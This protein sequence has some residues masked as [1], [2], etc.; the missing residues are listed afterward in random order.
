MYKFLCGH[1]FL[2]LW[3]VYLGVGF[4]GHMVNLYLTF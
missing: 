4:L 2:V 3:A 1:V